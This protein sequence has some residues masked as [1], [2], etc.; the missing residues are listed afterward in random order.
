MKLDTKECTRIAQAS[1][2]EYLSSQ[3]KQYYHNW[4]ETKPQDIMVG[5]SLMLNN[6][7]NMNR[8][9]AQLLAGCLR[10]ASNING[11][12]SKCIEMGFHQR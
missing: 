12:T 10:L 2:P 5:V 9:S 7:A 8:I 4:F 6:L 1:E 3:L 11:K